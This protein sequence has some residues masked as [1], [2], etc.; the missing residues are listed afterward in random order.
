VLGQPHRVG[1]QLVVV[2]FR[3]TVLRVAGVLLEECQVEFVR[4]QPGEGGF[5]FAFGHLDPKG[6]MGR[7]QGGEGSRDD[8]VRGGVEGG[9]PDGAADAGGR[10]VQVG[11]GLLEPL[12]DGLG[13][14]DESL[15]GRGQPDAAA[16]SFEQRYAGFGFQHAELLG[17][18]RRGIG[19]GVGNGGEGAAV[20]ELPQQP[21]PVQVQHA[22]P[23][24]IKFS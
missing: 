7:G 3:A 20:L 10:G 12:Q 21:E 16:R 6:G 2:E 5:R 18:G 17:D 19:E 23:P 15:G 22:R 1:G 13:V 8:R 24:I 11:P 9:H 4:D 14:L